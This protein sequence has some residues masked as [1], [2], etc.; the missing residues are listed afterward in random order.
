MILLKYYI[1]F[2]LEKLI[3]QAFNYLKSNLILLY[4]I[5]NI[6]NINYK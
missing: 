6:Y 3:N 4:N 5:N 1:N 2:F